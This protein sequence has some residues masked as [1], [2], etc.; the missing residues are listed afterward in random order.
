MFKQHV[1]VSCLE[2][3]TSC[4]CCVGDYAFLLAD[5][6]SNVAQRQGK[7]AREIWNISSQQDRSAII[8][9]GAVPLLVAMLRSD[10]PN[11]QKEGADTLG[12]MAMSALASPRCKV[13]QQSL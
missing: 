6:R 13:K 8:A 11:V 1:F 2:T 4:C 7:A 12:T 10:Q 3:T 5:L 9:A